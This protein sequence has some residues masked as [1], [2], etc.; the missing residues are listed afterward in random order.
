M[1]VCV[2]LTQ[3]ALLKKVLKF[4]KEGSCQQSSI[5][6]H[7]LQHFYHKKRLYPTGKDTT[8]NS[9]ILVANVE[10]D[11]YL[12]VAYITI[13]IFTEVSSSAQNVEN[14]VETAVTWQYTGEVIQERNYLNVLFVANDSHSQVTL[15]HTAEFTVVTNH[16]NVTCVSRLLLNR[17]V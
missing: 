15:L 6:V 12:R 9:C 4:M 1:F 17:E 16:T 13:Q 5:H 2:L 3:G 11:F 10:S 7:P 8:A 14:I